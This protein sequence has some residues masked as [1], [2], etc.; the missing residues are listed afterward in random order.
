[1]VQG[2]YAPSS[3]GASLITQS[4]ACACDYLAT[5][6]NSVLTPDYYKKNIALLG[7]ALM[8]SPLIEGCNFSAK[9][10]EVAGFLE[11]G[12]AD[13]KKSS[14]KVK[15]YI[16]S[17]RLRDF[18]SLTDVSECELACD[19]TRFSERLAEFTGDIVDQIMSSAHYK[20][21]SLLMDAIEADVIGH[22]EH[23]CGSTII[24]A[25][26]DI[27]ANIDATAG[28]TNEIISQIIAK[29]QQVGTQANDILFVFPVM[30][31]EQFAADSAK[32]NCCSVQYITTGNSPYIG[33]IRQIPVAALTDERSLFKKKTVTIG[34]SAKTGI[35]GY[36][37]S[38]GALTYA[39][40][41]HMAGLS[42]RSSVSMSNQMIHLTIAPKDQWDAHD[43]LTFSAVIHGAAIRSR[44]ERIVRVMFNSNILD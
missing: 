12:C 38:R 41:K 8:P 24:K 32:N 39:Y 2:I 7:Y 18:Y 43:G 17:G 33:T 29:F 25:D 40:R 9:K 35:A 19:I 13:E 15:R 5:A 28:L 23:G 21:E 31:V 22:E 34:G 1:M 42:T 20:I 30:A 16:R 4:C 10:S 36:A 37:I 11:Y 27:M 14:S 6:K 44:S 26:T 3:G